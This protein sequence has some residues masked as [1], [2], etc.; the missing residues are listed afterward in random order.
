MMMYNWLAGVQFL[1]FMVFNVESEF[2][3]LFVHGFKTAESRNNLIVANL[4][5]RKH[6]WVAIFCKT[7][8]NPQDKEA[9]REHEKEMVR[10]VE[11]LQ[12]VHGFKSQLDCQWA[13]LPP[14]EVNGFVSGKIWAIARL[15]ATSDV[16]EVEKQRLNAVS[17]EE[18]QDKYT[19]AAGE[20]YRHTKSST[21]ESESGSGSHE[22]PIC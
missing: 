15:G 1:E 17:L 2:L 3:S 8:P 22:G 19:E 20:L 7:P 12:G 21:P 5:L 10:V 4:T 14:A 9:T 18:A 13:L 11:C 16:R 6:P